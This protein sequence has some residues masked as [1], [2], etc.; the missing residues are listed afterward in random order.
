VKQ[1]LRTTGYAGANARQRHDKQEWLPPATSG[2]RSRNL[3]CSVVRPLPSLQV[4]PGSTTLA[5]VSFEL[6]YRRHAGFVRSLL[7]KMGMAA[8]VDDA[9]QDVFVVVHRRLRE[10]DGRHSL[11][12]WLY[13]IARRV[14]SHYRRSL[15]R[16]FDCV[17]LEYEVPDRAPGPLELAQQRETLSEI[18]AL[19]AEL[20]PDKRQVLVLADIEQRSVPEIAEMTGTGLSTIYTRLRRARQSLQASAGWQQLLSQHVHQQNEV[21]ACG[22]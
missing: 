9:L 11:R 5:A 2:S 14:A 8:S 6:V 1:A 3:H 15:R 4:T 20:D 22:Y 12:S 19:F 21:V 17:P 18:E 7:S 10:F 16:A 13:A